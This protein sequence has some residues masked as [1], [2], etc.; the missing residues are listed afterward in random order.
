MGERKSWFGIVEVTFLGS[1]IWKTTLCGSFP[2]LIALSGYIKAG[3]AFCALS[4]FP[5]NLPSAERG[6]RE[7]SCPKGWGL[8]T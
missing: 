6:E 5:V 3:N 1:K 8:P 7:S 2:F 4:F